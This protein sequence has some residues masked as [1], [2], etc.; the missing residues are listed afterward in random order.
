MQ[1]IRHRAS[2]AARDQLP[3]GPR[4]QFSSDQ[5]PRGAMAQDSP[6]P[7]VIIERPPSLKMFAMLDFEP[8]VHC[9]QNQ[10][11]NHYGNGTLTN[12]ENNN[13]SRFG[14]RAHFIQLRKK[15]KD[16]DAPPAGGIPP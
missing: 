15:A 4:C 8:N 12:N 5:E 1:L 13:Q 2:S 3:P 9:L 14:T 6:L 7:D 10:S 16:N 11:N